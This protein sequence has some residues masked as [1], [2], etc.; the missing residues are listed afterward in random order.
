[1]SI[2]NKVYRFIWN[3]V[4]FFLFRPFPTKIF[5]QWRLFLLAIF[6]AKVHKS[7]GVYASCK[8]WAPW[9]LI[10]DE[11]AWLG[12]N[13]DCY[14]VAKITI[15][16]N[17]TISQK[18]Y[19]CSASHDVTDPLNKLISA[20]IIIQDRVWIGADSFIGMG[21]TIGKGAVVGATAS[22]FKDVD[23]WTIVGGNP[24]KFLKNRVINE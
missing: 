18:S 9:N 12:P 4:W 20:P 10:L 3:I 22:V 23:P 8:I 1:M 2:K 24:S 21:V 13:V 14:N 11:N 16:A 5:N 19:L 15:G 17:S 7:S 6:G